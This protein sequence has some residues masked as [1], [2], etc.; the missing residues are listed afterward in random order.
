[1]RQWIFPNTGKGRAR[2][3]GL[4]L[5]LLVVGAVYLSLMRPVLPRK[6]PLIFDALPTPQELEKVV[7]DIQAVLG[8]GSS[9][10]LASGH[11]ASQPDKRARRFVADF[12]SDPNDADKRPRACVDVRKWQ[13]VRDR[14]KLHIANGLAKDRTQE[15]WTIAGHG[16]AGFFD[17][18]W[19]LCASQTGGGRGSVRVPDLSELQLEA[20]FR[21]ISTAV[22]RP[23][24]SSED[25]C[26]RELA[27]EYEALREVLALAR[28]HLAG[29]GTLEFA[30][31]DLGSGEQGMKF[32]RM[33]AA[34][35]PSVR[36]LVY[37]GT[38]CWSRYELRYT[39]P[40]QDQANQSRSMEPIAGEH[41]FRTGVARPILYIQR[42]PVTGSQP[43]VRP[44]E[45]RK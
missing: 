29:G 18:V 22:G 15:V 3:G 2:L 33:L 20:A 19:D 13:H 40:E 28:I 45:E 32:G 4:A 27:L 7:R 1:M 24:P 37:D 26:E 42:L 8:E 34:M 44:R 39:K 10:E 38:I 14:L 23:D 35:L 6:V 16:F 21:L 9:W 11:E 41:S 25:A 36:V 17:P 5:A 31:C 30:A 43:D 12:V